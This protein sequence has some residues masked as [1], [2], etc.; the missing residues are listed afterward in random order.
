MRFLVLVL[1]YFC[2]SGVDKKTLES[3]RPFDEAHSYIFLNRPIHTFGPLI[4]YTRTHH[5]IVVLSV[6]FQ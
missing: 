1:F 5:K 2:N 4:S 3:V 6:F